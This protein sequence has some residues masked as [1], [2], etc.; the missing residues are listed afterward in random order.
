MDIRRTR[1]IKQFFEWCD[2]RQ[3][4]FA[5]IEAISVATYITFQVGA[6]EST[7]S[8][9]PTSSVV[10]SPRLDPGPS[11]NLGPMWML[12]GISPSKDTGCY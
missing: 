6:Q 11:G 5:D 9:A 12:M 10:S 2:A 7:R 3:L 4:E 8:P 1:A